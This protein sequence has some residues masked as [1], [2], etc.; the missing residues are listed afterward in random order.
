MLSIVLCAILWLPSV[1]IF[2][3]FAFFA[4]LL[5]NYIYSQEQLSLIVILPLYILSSLSG[6][7]R[8]NMDDITS[9]AQ[10]SI[11]PN[12]YL[13]FTSLPYIKHE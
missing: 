3:W 4:A 10:D 7:P 1:I 13:R 9:E 11:S 12:E 2:C 6:E 8:E 5:S